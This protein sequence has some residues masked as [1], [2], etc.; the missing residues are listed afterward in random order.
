MRCDAMRRGASLRRE[1]GCVRRLRTRRFASHRRTKY[2][3]PNGNP[4]Y[5]KTTPFIIADVQGDYLVHGIVLN[6]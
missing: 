2:V 1:L 5:D 3:K 6:Y 4:V